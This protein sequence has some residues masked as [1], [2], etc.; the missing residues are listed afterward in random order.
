[1]TD[2]LSFF[3]RPSH[4]S[5][6]DVEQRSDPLQ[7]FASNWC[8]ARDMDIVEVAAH[9]RPAGDFGDRRG[10]SGVSLMDDCLKR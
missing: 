9:V 10:L 5:A 7:R 3:G 8:V 6:L 4:C 2:Q 1:L